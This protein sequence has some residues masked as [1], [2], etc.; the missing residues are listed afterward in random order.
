MAAAAAAAG[1]T[2]AFAFFAS[3][4][5]QA[6]V[7]GLGQAKN[8]M[9]NAGNSLQSGQGR[10]G[11][12]RYS[13]LAGTAGSLIGGTVGTIAGAAVGG[14][15][16]A[17]IGGT[18]G[19]ALGKLAGS[20]AGIP[21]KIEK[22]GDALMESQR[23]LMRYNATIAEAMM[24]SKRNEIQRDMKSGQMTGDSTK[25]LQGS[26]DELKDETRIMKDGATNFYNYVAGGLAKLTTAVVV[27]VKYLTG[28]AA[29]EK[30]IDDAIKAKQEAEGLDANLPPMGQFMK[31]LADGQQQRRDFNP[32][33][34]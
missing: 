31:A 4:E 3:A 13:K 28:I 20:I 10:S 12:D 5:G 34:D 9:G 23:H 19:A 30:M 24:T 17:V 15:V 32:P 33:A 27:G 26:M 14:P 11:E 7:Q 16:G 18:L 25:F 6:V 22:W 21:G 1:L 2:E 8:A 29:I